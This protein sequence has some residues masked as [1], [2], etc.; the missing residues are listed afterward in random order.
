MVRIRPIRGATGGRGR[1]GVGDGTRLQGYS[2]P[3]PVGGWNARDSIANMEETDAVTMDNWFPEETYVGMRNGYTS[4]ATGLGEAVESLMTWNGPSSSKMFGAISD[5]VYEVTSS[6][7]VGAAAISSLNSARWQHTMFSIS[8]GHYLYICNGADAPRYYNGT[9]WT[10]PTI[11]GSGLTASDLIHVNSFK[12]R[13]LFVEKD[14]LNAWYFPVETIAGT[15]TKFDLG[16]RASLGG[17][18]V[19]IGTWTRDG[20]DGP[21]DFCVFVTSEGQVIV[22][23]GTDP[24]D[25][26]AWGL[27]GVFRIGAPLGRRCLVR[28][29]GDLTIMTEDGF[30]Q[31]SRFMVAGRAST[32][33]ALSDRISKAV[34][35]AV[36]ANRSNFGWQPIH[37]PAGNMVLFN[38]PATDKVQFVSNATTRAWCR[39]TNIDARC[40]ELL[41]DELYFGSDGVVYKADDGLNDAGDAIEGQLDPAF[42]YFRSRGRGK[43]FAMVRINYE[44]NGRVKAGLRLN[45]DFSQ[46]T[47]SEPGTFAPQDGA[48]WDDEF[49]DVAEWGGAVQRFARWKSIEGIGDA[50]SLSIRTTNDGDGIIRVNSIDWKYELTKSSG[51][52]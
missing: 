21:D 15:I 16:P 12:G 9:T 10:T 5:K 50:A 49:W 27:V 48:E 52:I 42:S 35:E 11:T 2:T 17:H 20:G 19:A 33:A 32:R 37:Y 24:G 44:T 38:I 36:A 23:A 34:I 51:H 47:P 13:L 28:L 29:G 46:G 8:S 22:Y 1:H 7:A 3:A 39:F 14:T 41:D 43:R 18:L 4:H 31:L 45:T 25:A 30:S 6:G 26:D 40:W